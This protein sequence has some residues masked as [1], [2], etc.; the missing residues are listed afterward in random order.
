VGGSVLRADVEGAD[1]AK[2]IA[3][4]LRGDAGGLQNLVSTQVPVPLFD[5]AKLKRWG[6]HIEKLPSETLFV[7]KPVPVWQSN[8]AAVYGG[9]ATMGMLLVVLLAQMRVAQSDRRAAMQLATSEARLRQVVQGSAVSIAVMDADHRFTHWNHASELL[10]G[11]SAEQML[12]T[13]A[14]P[15]Q[16]ALSR[17]AGR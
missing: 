6:A 1:W 2:G 12:G 8:P 3:A 16:L 11:L 7:N 10:T 9:V 4:Y 13:Q 15:E 14:R 17:R 5:W